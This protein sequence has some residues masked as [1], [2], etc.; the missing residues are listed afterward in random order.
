MSDLRTYI[1]ETF[2]RKSVSP[3]SPGRPGKKPDALNVQ[4]FPAATGA[5]VVLF[6]PQTVSGEKR[7]IYDENFE[8]R[9]PLSV[10]ALAGPLEQAGYRVTIID[11]IMEP[12]VKQTVLQSLEGAICLGVSCTAGHQLYQ[13]LEVTRL[14][15]QR[16]PS[17]PIIWGGWFPSMLTTP[18]IQDPDVDIVV[19]GQGEATFLELVYRL[20]R[21][22]P[23][24]D[25]RG[26]A[27]KKDGRV[28]LTPERPIVDINSAPPLPYHLI[29]V[30]AHL[31]SGVP[32]DGK[33]TIS[34]YSSYGCPYQCT[35]CSN[36]ALFGPRWYALSPERVV[37]DIERLVKW[38]AT[39]IILDDAN[40]FV[41]MKRVRE[42]CE[43]VI[44]RGLGG[45]LE[46]ETTGTANVIHKFDEETLR[47]L[48]QSGCSGIFI[49]AETG[50]RELMEVFKKPITS[51][52]TLGAAEALGRHGITPHISFVIGIPGEPEEALDDTLDLVAKIYRANPKTNV[53]L[54]YFTPLPGVR[55][56]NS[57]QT[58]EMTLDV[59]QDLT[60]WSAHGAKGFYSNYGVRQFL[61]PAYRK[62][63]DRA[64]SLMFL[65]YRERVLNKNFLRTIL[66]RIVLFRLQHKLLGF[67]VV[68]NRIWRYARL[69]N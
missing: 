11:A 45:K 60:Q 33:R 59:P 10:M 69:D 17:L 48:K 30:N 46:W 54:F 27:Y 19:R 47:L 52:Q 21:N 12:D 4:E 35:F 26:I 49:G 41:S 63:V 38:G 28:V 39:K 18:T 64:K 58:H 34:Y 53:F 43:L 67:P 23:I 3:V 22:L 42:I 6:F 51:E 66:K 7:S 50:S 55:L 16:Y 5:P 20:S 31:E 32:L 56:S 13:A 65:M 37:D 40:Y 36:D 15:R 44:E 14:V 29:D 25:V 62:K 8:S 68:E 24:D 57:P 2:E 61:S 9:A 1:R